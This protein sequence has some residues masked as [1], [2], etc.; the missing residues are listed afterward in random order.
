MTTQPAYVVGDNVLVLPM[1]QKMY[2]SPTTGEITLNFHPDMVQY[3]GCIMEV[4]EVEKHRHGYLYRLNT[5]PFYSG[6]LATWAWSEE[7]LT[8]ANTPASNEEALR[9][10]TADKKAPS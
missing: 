8:L 2:F 3:I 6:T 5:P 1:Q 4:K 9:Y 10:L 7:F